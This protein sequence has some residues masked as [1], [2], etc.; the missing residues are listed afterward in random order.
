MPEHLRDYLGDPGAGAALPGAVA[1]TLAAAFGADLGGVRVHTGEQAERAAAQLGARAFTIGRDI[2]LG[3]GESPSDLALMAHEVTHVVQQ[4]AAPVA[5]PAV[6]VG[7]TGTA[8]ALSREA[9]PATA[10]EGPGL[11]SVIGEEL[12]ALAR[13]VPGYTLLTVIAGYDPIACEGVP[14]T[15]ERLLEGLLDLVPFGSDIV[16]RLRSSELLGQIVGA[17]EAGLVAHNL[18]KERFLREVSQTWDEMSLLEGIDGNLAILGR[19]LRAVMND[20]MGFAGQMVDEALALIRRAAVGLAETALE[21]PAIAPTWRLATKVF[22]R[23]PLRDTPVEAPTEEILGDFLH[24]AGRDEVLGQLRERGALARAAEWI[25]TQLARF[26][27]LFAEA[28]ALF[29]DAWEAIQPANIARLLDTVT[30]LAQRAFALVGRIMAFVGD[31]LAK[32]LELVK[33]ALLGWLSRVANG[34]RGFP[35]LTVVLGQDPFTGTPVARSAENLIKG[36]I[37][38]LPGGE[39]TYAKLAE[40]GVIAQ[41]GARIEGEMQRLGISFEMITGI[42]TGIWNTLSLQDLLDPIGAFTRVIDRFLEPIQ[43]LVEFVGTVIGVVVDLIL[44]LMDF[45]SDLIGSIIGNVTSSLDKIGEDPVGFLVHL[46]EALKT[47]VMGFLTHIG[48]HLAQGLTSWL[49]RGLG[50]VGLTVPEDFS[51]KGVLGL[52]LDVLGLSVETLW[53]KLGEEIGPEKVASIREG[54]AKLGEA[55]SFVVAV[56]TE[57]LSA[58]WRFLADKLSGLWDGLLAAAEN[59]VLTEI[60]EAAAAKLL[61]MLDPTGVMAV[62][63]SFVAFFRAV[64]SA[65]DYLRD[66][67]AIVDQYVSTIAAIAAGNI[68]PGAAKLEAALAAGIPVALGFLAAQ[69]GLSNVPEKLVELIQG[70]RALVDEALT[71]LVKQAVRIGGNALTALGFGGPEAPGTPDPA[72][73]GAPSPDTRTPE[74]K[75]QALDA[76]LAA[77]ADLEASGKDVPAIEAELPGIAARFGM[78]WLKLVVEQVD[79][80][81]ASV[82]VEGKV[83]PEGRTPTR[84]VKND[85]DGPKRGDH[86]FANG[87]GG[88]LTAMRAAVAEALGSTGPA[89][90]AL[91]VLDAA[92]VEA[93]AAARGIP[94][95]V[96]RKGGGRE[97]GGDAHSQA[98]GASSQIA[99]QAVTSL[100]HALAR[101]YAD[102]PERLP[103]EQATRHVAA[104]GADAHVQ[105]GRWLDTVVDVE[106]VPLLPKDQQAALAQ[107]RAALDRIRAALARGIGRVLSSDDETGPIHQVVNLNGRTHHLDDDG[108]GGTPMLHSVG[109]VLSAL[110]VPVF[111]ALMADYRAATTKKRRKELT[112]RMA[113]WLA[114]NPRFVP[115][116][117]APGIGAIQTHGT[118]PL[119]LADAGVPLWAMESEHVIP[120]TVIRRLWEVIGTHSANDSRKQL[121]AEDAGLT[122]IMIY[123]RAADR[124]TGVESSRRDGLAEEFKAMTDRY[125][126][127]EDAGTERPERVMRAWVTRALTREGQ[128]YATTTADAV[129]WEH[130][131]LDPA[132]GLTRGAARDE[133]APVPAV[134]A[135]QSAVTQEIADAT[136]ILEEALAELVRPQPEAAADPAAQ[137]VPGPG[138]PARFGPMNPGP[139][140]DQ[141]GATFRS[142]TYSGVVLTAPLELYRVYGGK[143]GKI[144]SYW[145]RTRPSGALQAQLDSALNPS[146][147]NS[148]TLV[149]VIR[150]PA[151]TTIYDGIAAGQAIDNGGWLVGGGSQV[152]IPK[153]D[154]SWLVEA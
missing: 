3:A 25:D 63:N 33:D 51:L 72:A 58:V 19:H 49:T 81:D 34:T 92:L 9:A 50:K 102:G 29:T 154:P 100:A 111:S 5:S 30:S 31:L 22:H 43:R 120:F 142:S 119:S 20:V 136:A 125:W 1:D 54:A 122:T 113:E 143:A 110:T 88:Q 53:T 17:I 78:A 148:A 146:W 118:K 139:L 133:A 89:A 26:G 47:G 28:V 82:H 85:G 37:C 74:Q 6:Q 135:I 55:W 115:G 32:L 138:D 93:A 84:K 130:A 18:T 36:F 105:V 64:Q 35:L 73:A 60:V 65:I 67:L 52:V 75:Q 150:V 48:T 117:G 7:A 153:V 103:A 141:I 114:A 145:T 24:L 13:H 151:G 8:P 112:Q 56:Q 12:A 132:S 79:G 127:R 94:E 99:V 66:I 76:G 147:G 91:S 107:G 104:A 109:V 108:P 69:V 57:G 101:F 10:E 68:A 129:T 86:I 70:L 38:L 95:L 80:A 45:P 123:E 87:L 106:S 128:W 23:D 62:I 42:F 46:L 77:A 11:L 59:W 149:A 4:G 71:W 40:S 124:K 140:P 131:Q 61:S 152:F 16:A 41:A 97:S 137:A 2:W 96:V 98:F 134:G 14:R 39:A 27:G 121:H 144:G 15:P 90:P 83:N 44:R 21:S 116:A 126:A